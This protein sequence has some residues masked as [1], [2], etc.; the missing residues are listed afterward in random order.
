MVSPGPNCISETATAA[1]APGLS[2]EQA[3]VWT[4]AL[5]PLTSRTR[6]S[7]DLHLCKASVHK[8]L[9]SCEGGAV[10]LLNYGVALAGCLF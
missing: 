6:P 10:E 2:A 9:C 4:V 5:R 8:Q 3:R 7:N 1:T